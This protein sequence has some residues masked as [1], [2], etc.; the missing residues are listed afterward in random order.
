MFYLV[1]TMGLLASQVRFCS[2]RAGGLIRRAFRQVRCAMR[3]TRRLDWDG[4]RARATFLR[5]RFCVRRTLEPIDPADEEENC[6]C[7][8]EKIDRERD[9]IA[10]I[11]SNCAYF[12]RVRR[13]V[14]GCAAVLRRAQH[15][16]F[17]REIEPATEQA[18]WR[19]DKVL[20]Q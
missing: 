6:P 15:N 10:V 13:C 20:N 12:R 8:D 11:P 9:E 3:T 7:N 17:I 14:K 19:H 16:K 18:D 5:D 2:N 1:Q 4:H